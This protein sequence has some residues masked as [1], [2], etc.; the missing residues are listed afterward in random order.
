MFENECGTICWL[1]AVVQLVL[2][3]LNDEDITSQL[4]RIF[5]NF[6]RKSN[7]KSTQ[8]LR[9]YLSEFM[10]DLENGQQDAFDFFV[11]LNSAPETDRESILNP[12]S[13]FT[14]NVMTCLNDSSH[15]SSSYQHDPEFYIS[16]N[17]PKDD[18][19]IQNIIENEFH[20]GTIIDDWRCQICLSQ[21]GVKRKI[22][23]EGLIPILS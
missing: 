23:E 8:S 22:I 19:T 16:I 9:N 20:E 1:N 4:K 6:K 10:S 17:I 21:G 18:E 3:T 12:I 13:L 15:S 5:Q 2:C 14:K 7:I 11:A